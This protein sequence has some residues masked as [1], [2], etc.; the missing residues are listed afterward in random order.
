MSALT[1]IEDFDVIEDSG[2][3]LAAGGKFLAVDHFQFEGAP[4]AF[5]VGIVVAVAFAA[6]G[7]DQASLGESGAIVRGSVLH[8]AIGMEQQVFGRLA[9]QE[10]HTQSL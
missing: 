8:A 10:G 9:V 2:L 4:E 6:H 3:G 5:D 1:V 7:G